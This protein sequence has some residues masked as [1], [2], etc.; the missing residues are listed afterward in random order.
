[1]RHSPSTCAIHEALY[2]VFVQPSRNPVSR[3]RIPPIPTRNHTS[4]VLIRFPRSQYRTYKGAQRFPVVTDKPYDENIPS[5]TVS[6]ILDGKVQEPQ[7]LFTLLG[8]LNREEEV[9]VQVSPPESDSVPL[10]RI[11]SR[12]ALYTAARE[13]EKTDK[14]RRKGLA[15][16]ELEMNW[17][18][19]GNDLA[20][21]LS[22]LK[23]F[24][25]QG[26]RVD[27]TLAPKKKGRKATLEEARELLQTLTKSAEET[28]AKILKQEGA[29]ERVMMLTFSKDNKTR[30][31]VEETSEDERSSM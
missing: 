21:R 18:I 10:V 13:K 6:L 2:R 9:L 23:E 5:S 31:A 8:T 28:G 7:R 30:N 11:Y 17:A 16:K 19:D 26:R 24:L 1:M 27:V 14:V 20:H 22:R 4:H 15:T 25:G 12:A 29:L 3:L